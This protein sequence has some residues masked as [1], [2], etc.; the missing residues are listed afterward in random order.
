MS[1]RVGALIMEHIGIIDDSSIRYFGGIKGT[2]RSSLDK[3]VGLS[4][5][6]EIIQY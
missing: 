5:V 4:F 1:C 3:Y 2:K 6:R